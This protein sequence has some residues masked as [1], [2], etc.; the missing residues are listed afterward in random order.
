V[1]EET[2][3]LEAFDTDPATDAGTDSDFAAEH[4]DSTLAG[5]ARGGPEHAEE[6][7]SPD[8]RAGMD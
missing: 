2:K 8:G 4:Q 7:E 1:T 6:P 3:H 5:Q